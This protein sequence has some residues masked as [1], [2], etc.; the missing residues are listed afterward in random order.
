MGLNIFPI[1]LCL[2]CKF[3]DEL[4]SHPIKRYELPLSLEEV[5]DADVK[6][7]SNTTSIALFYEKTLND[8]RLVPRVV[9]GSG[10][11][12]IIIW[13]FNHAKSMKSFRYE[14][15]P[16]AKEK[17]ITALATYTDYIQN[18]TYVV[19]GGGGINTGFAF[20]WCMNEDNS[21][22]EELFTAQSRK[23]RKAIAGISIVSKSP[24]VFIIVAS[25]DR[26]VSIWNFKTRQRLKVLTKQHTDLLL[27]M[28][29]HPTNDALHIVTGSWDKSVLFWKIQPDALVNNT[30]ISNTA[31][32]P[33]YRLRGHRKSVTTMC[34]HQIPE[35]H[36]IGNAEPATILVT[37]SLDTNVIVW[38]FETKQM[39]RTFKGHK[40]RV[41]AVAVYVDDVSEHFP[42]IVSSSDDCTTIIWDLATGHIVRTIDYSVKVNCCLAFESNFGMMIVTGGPK[43]PSICNLGST[44]RVK[45]ITTSP[46]TAINTFTPR[47]GDLNHR[48]NEPIV[49]IGT[50]DS[51]CTIYR[52][53]DHQELA[54]IKQHKSRINAV[55]IY[56]P[57][58]INQNPLVISCDGKAKI[59]VWDLYSHQAVNEFRGHEGAVLT[60][61]LY[62][63]AK[64]GKGKEVSR[65]P[66]RQNVEMPDGKDKSMLNL[67]RPMII[68]GGTDSNLT[69]WDL[70]APRNNPRP[71]KKIFKSHAGFV[72]SIV[73]HHPTKDDE[74]P[75]VITGSYDKTVIVR[76]METCNILFK[77]GGLHENYVFFISLYDPLAHL[78]ENYSSPR[79]EDVNE[80]LFRKPVLVTSSY[81]FTLGVWTLD[82]NAA[83]PSKESEKK[84]GNSLVIDSLEQVLE[85]LRDGNTASLKNKEKK[86]SSQV[87][88][89]LKEHTDSVTALNIYVPPTK[90]ENPLI[91]SG[92]IDRMV[93]IW[94]LF[95][96]Q[97]LQKLV[98]HTDRVCYI[99]TFLPE[100][101]KNPLVFSGSDDQKTI[102]WEDALYQ[103]PFMPCRDDVNRCFD[104]DCLEEDW[105][106]ITELT[107]QY[108]SKIFLENPHLFF[109][110]IKYNR[111][112][113]LLKFRKYLIVVLPLI[114]TYNQKNL[115]QYA[116]EKNDLISVRVILYCWTENLNKDISDL[117]TQKLYHACYF[118]PE[119]SLYP[120]ANKYPVEFQNFIICLRLVRNHY[121]L[122]MSEEEYHESYFTY[123][124]EPVPDDDDEDDDE[125][126]DNNDGKREEKD[127]DNHI[128]GV[129]GRALDQVGD[130]IDNVA[131]AAKDIVDAVQDAVQGA[132]SQPRNASPMKPG[133]AVYNE[134]PVKAKVSLDKLSNPDVNTCSLCLHP[135]FR[136]E[137]TGTR[138]RIAR[139]DILWR[140]QLTIRHGVIDFIRALYYRLTYDR[141][142]PQPV[143]SLMVPLR[144][145]A[146]LKESLKLYVKIARHLDSVDIFDS[147][148]G[149]VSLR[150]F[151]DRYAKLYHV[152]AT[153]TYL[154]FLV[155]F[156]TSIY[157]YEFYYLLNKFN[158]A[159]NICM[160][161][162]DGVILL[163]LIY[164]LGEEYVQ[165]TYGHKRFQIGL[166]LIHFTRDIWNALDVAV[167]ITGFPGMILRFIYD[168]DIAVGRCFLALCSIFMWCKVLYYMRPF[169]SSGPLG[170]FHDILLSTSPNS[171]FL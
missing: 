34:L 126:D 55:V 95:T 106:L 96:G 98:G 5:G 139:Y 132:F 58:D 114:H 68:A 86:K 2:I 123:E 51:T 144:N 160:H 87:V 103:K 167:L 102:V 48:Y 35:F 121:S 120:L 101:G 94:D 79:L 134:E 159:Q 80:S 104:S 133:V 170:K 60:L 31:D 84:E 89:H 141:T 49:L 75:W 6:T 25:Q 118:F 158:T 138:D 13:N 76:D 15:F 166:A 11:G 38:D 163:F 154:A 137:I 136:Y 33:Y 128:I 156:I 67:N 4:W 145:T 8:N 41:S 50:I 69:V 52:M 32:E 16:G 17:T 9:T 117:L 119:D 151:W 146:K 46:V 140:S 56:V 171:L 26:T 147:E 111:P 105:P 143:A 57:E 74:M 107:K 53:K 18:R 1:F 12:L 124:H 162:L 100:N 129:V 59:R 65:Q 43:G 112:N 19:A 130:V 20:I 122:L 83:K 153:L 148:V 135:D 64:V 54:K 72:R 70:L 85:A 78:G 81:D 155:L 44:E 71:L 14:P 39:L 157:V 149:T 127:D 125:D 113:F 165:I 116:V 63:P 152:Q 142:S 47:K 23:H 21:G 131:D 115:L 30:I 91:I 62:D 97:R 40:Q 10:S 66:Q 109:L 168:D 161:I 88:H 77:L 29:V 22:C 82:E 90:E 169:S 61:G 150:F 42:K 110:A 93:I 45:T 37:G 92:S 73:V 36:A 108:D 7:D 28:I 3:L 24:D 99:N 27:T 164:Y